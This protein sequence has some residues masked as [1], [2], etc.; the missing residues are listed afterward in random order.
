[1]KWLRLLVILFGAV[2]GF[3]AGAFAFLGL[4]E[5]SLIGFMFASAMII[6]IDY[7]INTFK[8]FRGKA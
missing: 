6:Y 2:P 7:I 1:M 3:L 8:I 5:F 4:L